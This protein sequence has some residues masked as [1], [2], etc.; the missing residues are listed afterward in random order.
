MMRLKGAWLPK[1]AWEYLQD[2]TGLSD[3][4]NKRYSD[5]F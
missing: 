2:E 3:K 1:L 5:L 4:S